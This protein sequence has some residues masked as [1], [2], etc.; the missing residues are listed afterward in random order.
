MHSLGSGWYEY[1][2]VSLNLR[3]KDLLAPVTSVKKQKERKKKKKNVAHKR[4]SRPD[5]RLGFQAKVLIPF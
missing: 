5:S 2:V 4:Q 3:L 1:T